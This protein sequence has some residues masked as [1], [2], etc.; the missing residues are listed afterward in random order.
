MVSDGCHQILGVGQAMERKVPASGAAID[1]QLK[2]GTTDLAGAARLD[3]HWTSLATVAHDFVATIEAG[4]TP[5]TDEVVQLS[6]GCRPF[7]GTSAS[8]AD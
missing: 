4:R 7:A 2:M 5:P 3:G 6:D 1:R 8:N